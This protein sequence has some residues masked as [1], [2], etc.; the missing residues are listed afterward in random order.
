M[1]ERNS[2]AD[3]SAD[4]FNTDVLF[5]DC[6]GNRSWKNPI[7]S[8][9]RS[10]GLWGYACVAFDLHAVQIRTGPHSAN[11]WLKQNGH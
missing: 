4:P 2:P 1:I 5:A 9:A 3:S 11:S 7:T 8:I 10:A 6:I